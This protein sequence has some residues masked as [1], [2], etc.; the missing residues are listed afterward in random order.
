MKI[1]SEESETKSDS[2]DDVN[3]L[4]WNEA[5][6]GDCNSVKDKFQCNT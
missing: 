1:E 4:A 3:S 5:T 2:D 6:G